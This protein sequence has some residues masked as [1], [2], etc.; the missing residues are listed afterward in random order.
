MVFPYTD[1]RLETAILLMAI[2]S[3]SATAKQT[4][5]IR[6]SKTVSLTLTRLKTNQK[7]S[8]NVRDH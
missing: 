3:A 4:E 7:I 6:T 2:I 5:D 1:V 8:R